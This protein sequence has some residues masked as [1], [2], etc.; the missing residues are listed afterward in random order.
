M[1]Y[2]LLTCKIQS[3]NIEFT[4]EILAQELSDLGFE[5]FEN[6]KDSLLAY[7]PINNFSETLFESLTSNI[8]NLGT[9]K[10]SHS[11]IKDQNWNEEWEKN[12]QPVLIA[13]KCYIRAP[14]HE[15]NSDVLYE[16]VME[17][18]MAFGTGHHETTSLMI[19]Q[20]LVLDFKG[21]QVLDMGCGT[22]V[23]SIMAS[24]LKAAQIL[25]IDID[26]W[27]FQSTVENCKVNHVDNVTVD[28]G[29]IDLILGKKF[30]IILANINRNIL[31]N[32][33]PSC[34]AVLASNGLL[35]MSGIYRS[36]FEIIKDTALSNGFK[37]ICL[38]EKNNWIA[39]LFTRI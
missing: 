19:E 2:I 11:I 26:E 30:D 31:L 15:K 8:F 18:K 25:A 23:L 10:Y 36:D 7:I 1:D 21:K 3:E 20:M 13:N 29:D 6:S 38:S 28:K 32:Q 17:P 4:S 39:I 33:I 27:A 35:L 34:S 9:V 24:M 22:G 16:I 14:F 5:S 12:F 37:Y